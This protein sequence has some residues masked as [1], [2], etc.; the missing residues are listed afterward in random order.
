MRRA[1]CPPR[2][3]RRAPVP[4]P[5]TGRGAPAR[6]GGPPPPPDPTPR[7]PPPAPPPGGAG[8]R[9]WAAPSL[10]RPPAPAPRPPR[11]PPTPAPPAPPPPRRARAPP[12]H[13]G[14]FFVGARH[15]LAGARGRGGRLEPRRAHDPVDH[16]GDVG[17]GRGLDEAFSTLPPPRFT[18]PR[19]HQPDVARPPLGG[20]LLE[21]IGVRMGGEGGDAEAL[22]LPRQHQQGRAADR[23]GGAEDRD[24]DAHAT[25]N[26]RNS[27]ALT[28]ST[29]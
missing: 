13:P 18:L 23:P 22:P 27:P 5:D 16:D 12:R 29:K 1:R 19:I 8:R 3:P 26:R 17:P 14:R 6:T 20:L 7:R 21:Q 2:P 10:G 4:T 28:G 9:R 25:P 11:T 24:A 15:A